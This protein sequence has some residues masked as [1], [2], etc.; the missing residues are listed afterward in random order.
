MNKAAYLA[1]VKVLCYNCNTENETVLTYGNDER[2]EDDVEIKCP[3]C[4]NWEQG[5]LPLQ[6]FKRID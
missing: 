1:G 6:S 5:S 3:A 4:G 2:Y